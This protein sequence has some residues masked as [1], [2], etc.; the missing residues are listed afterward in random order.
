VTHLDGASC[1]LI[2]AVGL[3][4]DGTDD[5]N[6]GSA[7]V[8]NYSTCDIVDLCTVS[9]AQHRLQY[10]ATVF[11]LSH[12]FL[13]RRLSLQDTVLFIGALPIARHRISVPFGL[14]VVPRFS[15]PVS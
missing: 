1:T 10:S 15:H 9:L 14:A 5:M 6:R 4:I 8:S 2:L 12:L 7:T 3:R 13:I 11:N